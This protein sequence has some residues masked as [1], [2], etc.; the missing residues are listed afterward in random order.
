M[1]NDP[2]LVYEMACHACPDPVSCLWFGHPQGK[3]DES[4]RR[5]MLI[6]ARQCGATEHRRVLTET[7]RGLGWEIIDIPGVGLL[8]RPPNPE[9]QKGPASE[10]GAP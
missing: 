9:N 3:C 4:R 7:A 1:P 5:L 2:S 6:K 8:F 10:G